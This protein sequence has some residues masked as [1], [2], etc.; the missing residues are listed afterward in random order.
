MRRE[1]ISKKII[2]SEYSSYRKK[3]Q[4]FLIKDILSHIADNPVRLLD[5]GPGPGITLEALL[6][7][8][9]KIF[10]VGAEVDQDHII[11]VKPIK[12]KYPNRFSFVINGRKELPFSDNSFDIVFSIAALHHF[13]CPRDMLTEMVRVVK[14]G[15]K[16]LVYDINP[17]SLKIK[18]LSRM[19]SFANLFFKKAIIDAFI[20]SVKVSYKANQIINMVGDIPGVRSNLTQK[21]L[22]NILIMNKKI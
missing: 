13:L 14:R 1:T 8:N 17:E 5:V 11:S 12:D 16:V 9:G 15:G 10:C 18:I 21:Y 19:Y 7:S 6:E 22:Y 4:I 2:L 20:D 3:S